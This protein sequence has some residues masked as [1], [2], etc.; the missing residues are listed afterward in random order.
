MSALEQGP[1]PWL[2]WAGRAEQIGL[3]LIQSKDTMQKHFTRTDVATRCRE[4]DTNAIYIKLCATGATGTKTPDPG[5]QSA[6]SALAHSGMGI[7][8]I[9][10]VNLVP[11]DSTRRKTCYV[12]LSS[13]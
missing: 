13:P 5:A 2:C 3:A 1:T 11:S 10:D 12:L 6:Q 7:G 8:R 9:E 4:V